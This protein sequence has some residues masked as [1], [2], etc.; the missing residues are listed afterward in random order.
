MLFYWFKRLRSLVLH[1]IKAL[2]IENGDFKKAVEDPSL[3]NSFTL[4]GGFL[5]KRNKLCIPKNPLR[6]LIVEEVHGGAVSDH[7]GIDKTLEILKKQFYWPKMGGDVHKVNIR[8]A[9][10]HMAKS[11]FHQ[12]FYTPFS[13]P[14]RP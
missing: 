6:D 14:S 2:Y 13:L 4:R 12:R 8:C 10:C 9:T 11:Q 7:F 1:S 3:Y 5:S